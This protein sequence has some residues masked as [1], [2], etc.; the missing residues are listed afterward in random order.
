MITRS[1]VNLELVSSW[2]GWIWHSSV[3]SRNWDWQKQALYWVSK[4]DNL[5]PDVESVHSMLLSNSQKPRRRSK[6][7]IS[8]SIPGQ[9]GYE[10]GQHYHVRTYGSIRAVKGCGLSVG[11]DTMYHGA[12]DER[13][14]R[15]A[16]GNLGDGRFHLRI[17]SPKSHRKLVDGSLVRSSL[18]LAAQEVISGQLSWLELLGPP[19]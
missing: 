5:K 8:H 18:T 16:G 11:V 7:S 12:G 10:A 19:E 6:M 2:N 3:N 9:C 1:S 4:R 13:G 15:G 17:W 14:L